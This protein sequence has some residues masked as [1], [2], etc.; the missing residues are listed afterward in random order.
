MPALQL[1]LKPVS[2]QCNMNC[3]YCFYGDIAGK[4]ETAS[5]GT[6]TDETLE[7]V[8][9]KALAYA[10]G[11]CSFTFQ[12]GEPTLA[13]LD[14]F[15]KVIALQEKY[16]VKEVRIHNAVQTNGLA[17]NEEWCVFL[18]QNGFLAG[19]SLD[20][21]KA[22]N[23]C[24]RKDRNGEGT[25]FRIMAAADLFDRFGVEY[26]ILTVV[27]KKT[28]SKAGKIYE[29]YKKNGFNY[30]Q[31]IACLDPVFE[32]QG[33]KEYSLSPQEYGGFL[34]ELF[35]LWYMD[36]QNGCQPYI[37]Q[38]E[39]YVAVLMGKQPES[40]EQR[41]V[42]G[43]QHVVEADGGV[44]PCD[45]Y[46]LDAYKLGNLNQ[47]GFEEIAAKREEAG[48]ITQS[49]NQ[50]KGCRSCSYFGLCRGGCARHRT[51][52]AEGI[53]GAGG[54]RNYFCEGYRIFFAHC[55]GRLEEIAG[56]LAAK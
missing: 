38:F 39:N 22:V 27:N 6:M 40:C 42:C 41:G 33:K 37:R 2:G 8:I 44:Y 23:D 17:V 29:F 25:F 45:F 46:T 56:R 18:K 12:G 54:K 28:A 7:Q 11:W 53:G 36:L 15:R 47:C 16:N 9:K 24:Y 43:I 5:Y 10:D 49:A 26:N 52:S 14:F 30:Q 51:E 20:G 13:G 55:L 48:F 35:D 1:M 50:D 19:L 3:D 31:Y 4:R 32:K 34:N 21:V